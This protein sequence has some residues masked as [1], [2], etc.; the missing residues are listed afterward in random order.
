M[1]VCRGHGGR[2][3]CVR[4]GKG[5]GPGGRLR[6]VGKCFCVVVMDD[7]RGRAKKKR[8]R[9]NNFNIHKKLRYACAKEGKNI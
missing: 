7:D 6:L 8:N 5:G 4:G 3:R 9:K 1:V 2:V